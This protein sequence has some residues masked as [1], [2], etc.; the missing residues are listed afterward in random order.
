MDKNQDIEATEKKIKKSKKKMVI[1]PQALR[2][3]DEDITD[4]YLR[5]IHLTE[6]Q[7]RIIDLVYRFRMMNTK[8][9]QRALGYKAYSRFATQLRKLYEMR[10]I[11]RKL[12]PLDLRLKTKGQNG[13]NELYHMLDIAGAMFIRDYYGYEKL[14][15][16]KWSQRENEVKYD[17]AIHSLQISEVY[18]QLVVAVRERNEKL[19]LKYGEDRIIDAIADK[20]LYIRFHSNKDYNF[21]PDMFFK[22][23]R[24][25]KVYGFFVEV[26]R[27]T[28]AMQGLLNTEAFDS[29]VAYYE[30][31]K[32]SKSDYFGFNVMPKVL[33]ITTSVQRA[34]GLAKAVREKQKE[35][36]KSGVEFLFTV[37]KLWADDP[38]G[39]IFKD[40]TLTISR[41]MIEEKKEQA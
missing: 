27:G 38:F 8:D 35:L 36:G 40:K 3:R 7:K 1:I 26:D 30:G 37:F 33:V 12:R 18:S 34:E 15:E 5:K 32:E 22:Y 14:S 41:S 6:A 4:E 29:K 20:H 25:N 17:Y 19:S 24:D 23:I 31:Y 39:K 16:V 2:V 28:M 10:F 11:E 13:E 9:I 21:S